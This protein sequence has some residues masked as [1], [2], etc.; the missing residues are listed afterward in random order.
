MRIACV[1]SPRARSTGSS[2]WRGTLRSG[3]QEGSSPR[4]RAAFARSLA[5]H[6]ARRSMGHPPPR[7]PK[8]GP[9]ARE[10]QG[11]RM[12]ASAISE[13]RTQL[14]SVWHLPGASKR[15]LSSTDALYLGVP[16]VV[17]SARTDPSHA[18]DWRG[19][20][21]LRRSAA[22][23]RRSSGSDDRRG[24][25]GW[26]SPTHTFSEPPALVTITAAPNAKPKRPSARVGRWRRDPALR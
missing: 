9:S 20:H 4:S 15:H 7:W 18:L 12:H 5:G 11:V 23:Q 21:D 17:G 2:R 26:I 6:L 22:S 25:A 16:A 14:E 24:F 13:Q 1:A 8:H 3:K 10:Q 19:H